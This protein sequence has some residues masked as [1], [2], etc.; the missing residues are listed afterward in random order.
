MCR[1]MLDSCKNCNF[2][3][4]LKQAAHMSF[5]RVN[6]GGEGGEARAESGVETEMVAQDAAFSAN[7]D[8]SILVRH[9]K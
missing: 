2:D 6:G 3:V 5:R 8:V 4:I 7:A 1:L 9:G